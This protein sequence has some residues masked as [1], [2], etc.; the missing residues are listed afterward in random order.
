ML[1]SPHN[2]AFLITHH[3][4]I[5][6]YDVPLLYLLRK[7]HIHSHN[8]FPA[9]NARVSGG[10]LKCFANYAWIAANPALLEDCDPSRSPPSPPTPHPQ[11]QAGPCV[12]SHLTKASSAL[13]LISQHTCNEQFLPF[14][15][16]SLLTLF[17]LACFGKWTSFST[18]SHS[19]PNGWVFHLKSHPSASV[20]SLYTGTQIVFIVIT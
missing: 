9:T 19:V 2:L 8:N 15:G 1:F 14:F 4:C 17:S 6:H 12:V 18:Q 10:L 3:Y 5:S 11:P 13:R 7:G 20:Y 16:C